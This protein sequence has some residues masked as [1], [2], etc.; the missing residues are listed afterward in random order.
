MAALLKDAIK[1]NLVQTL[2]THLALFTAARSQTLHT[3]VTVYKLQS[4][5]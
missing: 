5:L 1:P 2:D 3:A 4:L